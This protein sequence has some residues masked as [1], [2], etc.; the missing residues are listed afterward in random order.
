MQTK[1]KTSQL[2]GSRRLSRLLPVVLPQD[3]DAA[4]NPDVQAE[5]KDML[6]RPQRPRRIPQERPHILAGRNRRRSRPLSR[7]QEASL[8]LTNQIIKDYADRHN[9]HAGRKD[10][11][12]IGY[13]IQRVKIRESKENPSH[14]GVS[15]RMYPLRGRRTPLH[16]LDCR[17]EK[18]VGDHA[19]V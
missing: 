12:I 6:L 2:S 3:D 9:N 10:R 17:R 7:E 15:W 11:Q 4:R 13:Q 18:H 14:H 1:R 19:A 5:R 16:A 8:T